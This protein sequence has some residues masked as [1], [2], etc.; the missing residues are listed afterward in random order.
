LKMRAFRAM[1]I[2]K[3][4]R[5]RQHSVLENQVTSLIEQGNQ[6][7]IGCVFASFQIYTKQERLKRV[8]NY[9]YK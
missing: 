5:V 9:R 4:E 7:L 8:A 3:E 1:N 2:H 6:E